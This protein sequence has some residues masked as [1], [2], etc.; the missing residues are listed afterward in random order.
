M[1]TLNMNLILLSVKGLRTTSHFG[2]VSNAYFS[3]TP[4]ILPRISGKE[5]ELSAVPNT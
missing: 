3:M 4:D 5:A 1:V 2:F